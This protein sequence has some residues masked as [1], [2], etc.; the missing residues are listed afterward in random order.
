LD[1][2]LGFERVE[3]I[4]NGRRRCVRQKLTAYRD[5]EA[6]FADCYHGGRNEAYYAGFTP[7]GDITDIDICGAYTT[8]MAAIR[9]P[10]WRGAVDTTDIVALAEVGERGMAF[11]RVRFQFPAETRFPCLPVRGGDA[12]L[13]YP[14]S[15]TSY[16]TG[17][18]LAVARRLGADIE[19]ERG[20][21]VPWLD[22]RHPFLR[23]TGVI[24]DIRKAH[25]KGSA[26]ELSGKEIGNSL[27]GKV[28]QGIDLLKSFEGTGKA[29]IRGKRVFDSRKGE[30]TTLPPS[31]ISNAALAAFTTG[32][33]RAYLAEL[34][35]AVPPEKA[36]YTATTDGLL[37]EAALTELKDTGPL[38]TMFAELRKLVTGHATTLDVRRLCRI[39]GANCGR[40][41]VQIDEVL[42]H[43]PLLPSR[44]RDCGG[45]HHLNPR[46]DLHIT[47]ILEYSKYR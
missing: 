9:T 19:V 28:A 45:H 22:E 21:F 12:G 25:P 10:D 47:I 23:F 8:A 26:F 6:L 41:C 43:E 15:G 29:G 44:Q 37:T 4:V 27:Y 38:A 33:V 40:G 34:L 46:F 2:L 3:T 13:I 31:S 11:A 42:V 18:E 35:A 7:E 32:L 1:D 36:V 30:M 14:L 20:V 24:N 39:S 5:R 16:A 17:P